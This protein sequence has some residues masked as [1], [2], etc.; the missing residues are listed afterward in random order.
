MLVG[1]QNPRSR[2]ERRDERKGKGMVEKNLNRKILIKTSYIF[3]ILFRELN[4]VIETGAIAVRVFHI[5]VGEGD[6]QTVANR[7]KHGPGAVAIV[8][9]WVYNA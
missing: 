1:S 5:K 9:V 4:I 8:W 7:G 3:D 6:V 2:G